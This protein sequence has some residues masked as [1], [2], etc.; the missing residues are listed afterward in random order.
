[1]FCCSNSVYDGDSK[2]RTRIRFDE[3]AFPEDRAEP[4]NCGFTKN[5]MSKVQ[6]K[7]RF[8]WQKT[9]MVDVVIT[10]PEILTAADFR[11]LARINW[12]ILVVDEAHR[13][14]LPRPTSAL[15]SLM[16]KSKAISSSIYSKVSRTTNHS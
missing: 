16:L 3:F 9:W 14:F 2:D 5:C 8:N 10:S 1:M 12:E 4:E 13:K 11:E 15:L 6:K 7:W